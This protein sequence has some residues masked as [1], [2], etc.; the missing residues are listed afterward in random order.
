M[1]ASPAH[2]GVDNLKEFP[3]SKFFF[4]DTSTSIQSVDYTCSGGSSGLLKAKFSAEMLNSGGLNYTQDS[5]ITF[6]Q[7]KQNF[8]SENDLHQV[9]PSTFS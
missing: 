4:S 1:P 5:V 7:E 8:F 6:S 2:L 3:F 9:L